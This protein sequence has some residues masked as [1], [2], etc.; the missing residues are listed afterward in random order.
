MD[1]YHFINMYDP[2]KEKSFKYCVNVKL[3]SKK[4]YMLPI[5]EKELAAKGVGLIIFQ[6]LAG[7]FWVKEKN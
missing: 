3:F 1:S 6:S 5:F 4:A 7:G 2:V